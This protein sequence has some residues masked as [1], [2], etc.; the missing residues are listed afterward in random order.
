[1][2]AKKGVFD[3][4]ERLEVIEMLGIDVGDDGDVG[5]QFQERAV[6]L[7]RFDHHPVAAA[8]RAFVP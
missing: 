3:R 4:V 6:A 2:K 5:G 7:V 8:S 1:M